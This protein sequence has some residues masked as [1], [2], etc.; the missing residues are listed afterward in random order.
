MNEIEVF[1]IRRRIL[2]DL[3]KIKV[4]IADDDVFKSAD[5]RKALDFNGKCYD[6]EKSGKT[7]G[8]NIPW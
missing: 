3:S 2:M 6:S 5:I 4:V 8:T 1:C 7:V